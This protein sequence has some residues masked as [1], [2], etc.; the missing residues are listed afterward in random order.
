MSECVD[1]HSPQVPYIAVL[2]CRNASICPFR[3]RSFIYEQRV[4]RIPVFK[5]SSF[6][7]NYQ[8]QPRRKWLSRE[9]KWCD[10]ERSYYEFEIQ[11]STTQELA[12]CP[13]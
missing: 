10:M 9:V 6:K 3:Q 11:E 13:P 8:L 7:S 5:R 2:N 12:R 4:A 1:K